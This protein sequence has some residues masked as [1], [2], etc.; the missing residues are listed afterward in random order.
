M[1]KEIENEV[2]Q[3]AEKMTKSTAEGKQVLFDTIFNLGPDGLKKAL[4]LLSPEQQ[5]IVKEAL[6]E[7]NK[8]AHKPEPSADGAHLTPEK[9]QTKQAKMKAESNT[10]SDD[11]DEK[12]M[13]D[14]NKDIKHQ[15]GPSE[16]PEG[17][18]GQVVKAKEPPHKGPHGGVIIGHTRDGKP[19]Y[20]HAGHE[21]HKEFSPEQHQ[22]AAGEHQKLADKHHNDK[23]NNPYASVSG[24]Q[25]MGG[26]KKK[27]KEAKAQYEKDA[28]EHKLHSES[29]AFHRR[30]SD[31]KSPGLQIGDLTADDHKAQADR[32]L[33]R[34]NQLH[35][36]RKCG[37]S[38]KKDM[39]EGGA[40]GMGLMC[41]ESAR[42]ADA[43]FTKAYENFMTKA[44]GGE[45]SKGGKVIGHTQSGKPIY[46]H[47]SETHEEML[48][49]PKEEHTDRMYAHRNVKI[50]AV[51]PVNGQM[52]S[53]QLHHENMEHMHGSYASH[54]EHKDK[55]GK[56]NKH[57]SQVMLD[58]AKERHSKASGKVN[59]SAGV[60]KGVSPEK[61][62]DCVH[63]VKAEGHGKV[64]AIKICNASM[65]KGEEM[66]NQKPELSPEDQA[67]EKLEKKKMRKAKKI[68]KSIKKIV[69]MAKSL[70][71]TQADVKKAIEAAGG[72][73]K[74]V[75]SEM[76]AKMNPEQNQVEIKT[77]DESAVSA[78]KPPMDK[79]AL[80]IKP[81]ETADEALKKLPKVE[82]SVNWKLKSSIAA[83]SLG[84]NTHWDVDAYIEKSE[85]E[86]QDIIKKGG[87]FGE[88]AVEELK[89]SETK[90]LD[91][92]D[93]LEKGYDKYSTD[94]IARIE[95]NGRHQPDAGAVRKSNYD[96]EIA[97][98]M[99]MSEEEYKKIFGSNE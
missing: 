80:E 47:S 40:G 90:K 99:G 5:E 1:A 96:V 67:K 68:A 29:S 51:Q 39:G 20:E 64:S 78:P 58:T 74:I 54:L 7:M 52:T 2:E 45:G 32:H 17:W 81:D 49:L 26:K 11:Q 76:K 4:P 72:N 53:E 12:L 71:L 79:A 66:E 3:L 69:K 60:P 88:A 75:K 43:K 63:D 34:V 28:G 61:H 82:K 98:S 37:Y 13:E 8:A 70:G 9:T 97:A 62:E 91:I 77:Q 44:G 15:G 55:R 41:S 27:F 24:L 31:S 6:E 14:K 10:G 30:M 19:I 33:D 35:E 38:M 48:K 59:K 25:S 36:M 89:K 95:S 87:Y 94:E 93:M 23:M 18:E 50:N 84:R 86:K 85:Q 42:E 16:K 56:S 57:H 83:G 21:S 22:D 73:L 46:A 65:S 92:N